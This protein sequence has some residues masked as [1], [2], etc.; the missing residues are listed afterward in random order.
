[1]KTTL[2]PFLSTNKKIDCLNGRSYILNIY[3][4]GTGGT[5]NNTQLYNPSASSVRA[6]ID[7]IQ[8]VNVYTTGTHY[9]GKYNTQLSNLV[10]NLNIVCKTGT[11]INLETRREDFASL[12]TPS[13]NLV[14]RLVNTDLTIINLPV[15]IVLEPGEGLMCAPYSPSLGTGVIYH[16]TEEDI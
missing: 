7:L 1:M 4:S 16:I 2:P 14:L 10:T 13:N 6:Y 11:T 3:G 15:S 9:L 8:F 12:T 5:Y